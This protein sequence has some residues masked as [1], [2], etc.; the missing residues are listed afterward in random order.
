MS[1]DDGLLWSRVR[2]VLQ[3]RAT[4]ARVLRVDLLPYAQMNLSRE[5]I[6]LRKIGVN[7]SL[8]IDTLNID[9]KSRLTYIRLVGKMFDKNGEHLDDVRLVG[10]TRR[11]PVD[12]HDP[13]YAIRVATNRA[14]RPLFSR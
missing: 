14:L 8:E 12:A 10:R 9:Q 11:N 6:K 2:A 4:R 5:L 7:V 3:Q 1:V 13:F